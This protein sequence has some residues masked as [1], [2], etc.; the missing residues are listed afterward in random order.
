MCNQ[1]TVKA[2][3][4]LPGSTSAAT[5]LHVIAHKGKAQ[6]E[7]FVSTKG[8]LDICPGCIMTELLTVQRPTPATPP[9]A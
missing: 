1:P 9:T 6:T 8:T 3:P 4:A 7:I 5:S 2:A